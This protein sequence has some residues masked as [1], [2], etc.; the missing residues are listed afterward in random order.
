MTAAS[1]FRLRRRCILVPGPWVSESLTKNLRG[2]ESSDSTA[3][4]PATGAH[5]EAFGRYRVRRHLASGGMGAVYLARDEVLAREVAIKSIRPMPG[6]LG[7]EFGARFL[8]EARCVA[9]LKHPNIVPIFDLGLEG[10]SPYLVMEVVEGPSLGD[11]IKEQQRIHARDAR[12]IGIQIANALAEAHRAGIVH[13][14]LKPGNILRASTE[15]WKLVDFG[16]AHVPDSSLTGIGDFLGTPSYAAPESLEGKSFSAHSDVYGLAATLYHAL[17]GAPPFGLGNAVKIALRAASEPAPSL[18]IGNPALPVDL[19]QIID[20]CLARLPAERP[21]AAELAEL[22]ASARADSYDEFQAERSSIAYEPTALVPTTERAAETPA[23]L[24]RAGRSPARIWLLVAVLLLGAGTLT[25]TLQDKG[26]SSAA[27]QASPTQASP[28]TP[29]GASPN[30][31]LE[32][33][34]DVHKS[35]EGESA[36][37]TDSALEKARAQAAGAPATLDESEPYAKE[38]LDSREPPPVSSMPAIASPEPGIVGLDEVDALIRRR[39]WLQATR[40]LDR[41]RRQ[42]P[43]SAYLAYLQGSLFMDHSYWQDGL[44]AYRAAIAKDARY[45]DEPTIVRDAIRGLY[46][47]S[48]PWMAARFIE[49]SLGASA[50]PALLEAKASA[51]NAQVKGRIASLLGK[52]DDR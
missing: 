31:T 23:E 10:D 47:R 40:S 19:V 29:I 46:S 52:L 44:E 41:L 7:R 22:L 35:S 34:G 16:V 28:P 17:S 27:T 45:A 12:I 48:K 2:G 30:A 5:P 39:S 18:A 9:S 36:P 33:K 51:R 20:R 32:V 6:K 14:D 15:T 50:R 1:A 43:D 26:P 21:T 42:Y 38:E 24:P 49:E 25:H 8:N 13:R 37:F 11:I 3:S 4:E